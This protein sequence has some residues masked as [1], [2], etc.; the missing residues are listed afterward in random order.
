ME[1]WEPMEPGNPGNRWNP[2]T[3]GTDGT[4]EPRYPGNRYPGNPGT[5][6]PRNPGTRV[7]DGTREPGCRENHRVFVFVCAPG[8]LRKRR[9]NYRKNLQNQ[10]EIDGSHFSAQKLGTESQRTPQM[11][12]QS[13]PERPKG[14]PNRHTGAPKRPKSSPERPR[15]PQSN[16]REPNTPKTL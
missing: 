16:T 8:S 14:D 13:A 11:E 1:P 2:G 6:V 12:A 3:L 10:P 4:R 15:P 7:P 5:R 9:R